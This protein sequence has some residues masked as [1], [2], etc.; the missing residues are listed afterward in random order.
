MCMLRIIK[1]YFD[2]CSEVCAKTGREGRGW[3]CRHFLRAYQLYTF[4][5]ERKELKEMESPV[6]CLYSRVFDRR[7]KSHLSRQQDQQYREDNG[8]R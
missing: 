1:P 3:L 6:E 2:V 8:Y 5:G 4:P 7:G